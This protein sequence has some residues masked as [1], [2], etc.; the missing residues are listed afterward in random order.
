MNERFEVGKAYRARAAAEPFGKERKVEEW[1][2]VGR[3]DDY[4]LPFVFFRKRDGSV[5]IACGP[6]YG[7]QNMVTGHRE[8]ERT[9]HQDMTWHWRLS[10]ADAVDGPKSAGRRGRADGLE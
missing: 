7:M 5:P 1:D 8:P 9:S 10:A 6:I 2:C 4:G 3:T